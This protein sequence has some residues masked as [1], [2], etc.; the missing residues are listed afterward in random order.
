[1]SQQPN[2]FEIKYRLKKG[3]DVPQTAIIQASS[4]GTA[5]KIFEQ[6]NPGCVVIQ[7]SE[8]KR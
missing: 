1:M 2:S 6:S 8:V 7:V 5:R 4:T 3:N